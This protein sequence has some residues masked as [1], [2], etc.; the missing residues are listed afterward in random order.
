MKRD[1]KP[2]SK[3]HSTKSKYLI[4]TSQFIIPSIVI[5]LSASIFFLVFKSSIFKAKDPVC[6]YDNNPCSDAQI[7]AEI[8]KYIGSNLITLKDGELKSKLMDGNKAIKDISITKKLPN[9]LVVEITPTSPAVAI[10]VINNKNEWVVLNNNLVVT[11]IVNTDPNLPTIIIDSSQQVQI[12]LPIA[13]PDVAETIL[14]AR[15]ITEQ[16]IDVERI[17]L[18]DKTIT[19]T[20]DSGI[21]ALLTTIKDLDDQLI[22]LQAILAQDKIIGS[23]YIVVD[24]RFDQPVL[25]STL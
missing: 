5:V 14:L 3:Y 19:L 7:I 6:L 23:D 17:E 20:F 11:N 15:K 12:G 21:Y 25:K 16:F 8:N 1:R 18:S 22:T 10:Q 4:I 2:T 13:D 24:V 9:L